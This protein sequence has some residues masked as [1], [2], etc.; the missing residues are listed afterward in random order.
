MTTYQ[1]SSQP[2]PPLPTLSLIDN[3]TEETPDQRFAGKLD[4]LCEAITLIATNVHELKNATIEQGRIVE[5]ALQLA[6]NQQT[7]MDKFIDAFYEQAKSVTEL[8]LSLKESTEA[9]KQL[10]RAGESS[11]AIAKSHQEAI[12]DLLQE[13]RQSRNN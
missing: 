10:A 9:A 8:L 3:Q 2:F 12:R 7:G 6:A 4:K 5:K 1:N 13:L 11:Q